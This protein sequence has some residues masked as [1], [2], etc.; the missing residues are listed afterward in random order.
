MKALLIFL[1][2]TTTAYAQEYT[3]PNN[4]HEYSG[5]MKGAVPGFAKKPKYFSSTSA[6]EQ[7]RYLYN[8]KGVRL[9]I[10][11]DH[12]ENVDKVIHA[13]N[14]KYPGVDLKH[15]CRKIRRSKSQYNKN[16][17]LFKEIS[18]YIGNV[19]F[20]IHCRYGAHR[21]VTALTGA[22]ISKDGVSFKEAFERTGGK[23]KH[24]R[25]EGQKALLNQARKF[26]KDI[27]VPK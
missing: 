18:Q 9:I 19:K 22:W 25:S 1:L 7:L 6:E 20:F 13:V 16:V 8:E 27:K 17:E 10:S 21:A 12:C 2:L 14:E 11:L 15:V 24:F 4:F 23:K 5:A 3:S 26:A